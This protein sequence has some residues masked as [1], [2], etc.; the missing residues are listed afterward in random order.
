MELIVALL[1]VAIGIPVLLVAY[2]VHVV[3]D[4]RIRR[5]HG[6]PPK[7]YL[8]DPEKGPTVIFTRKL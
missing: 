4:T 3:H 2:Y 7:K 1:F 6:L 5:V 8:D